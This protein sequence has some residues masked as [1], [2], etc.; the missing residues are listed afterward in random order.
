MIVVS[1]STPLI[2]LAKVGYFNLLQK[3]FAEITIS[4]EVWN[5]VVVKGAGRSGSVETA[6]AS[7]IQVASLADPTQLPVWRSIYN[8]GAGEVSTILLAK[9]LS[10]SL[11]LIDER[12]ARRLATNERL[13]ISGSIAVL[14]SGYR[15]RHVNDLRQTYLD[16]LAAKIWIDRAK[17]NRSLA[18]LGLLPL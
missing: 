10:A 3:L 9:E 2:T 12:K 16:L 5:E 13:A 6:E 8:L 15:K 17:L 18:S 11:A 4:R 7:W 14:E 1:N